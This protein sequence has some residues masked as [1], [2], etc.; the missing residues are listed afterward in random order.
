MKAILELESI[1]YTFFLDGDMIQ[2]CYTGEKLDSTQAGP[3]LDIIRVNKDRALGFLR[4]RKGAETTSGKFGWRIRWPADTYI[5]VVHGTWQ[6][7]DDGR[8]EA[9][10][11]PEQLSNALASVG[12]TLSPEQ[13]VEELGAYMVALSA[14]NDLV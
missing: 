2:Y 5:A 4:S 10:Y 9:E 1:G 11:T 14:P 12:Y 13:I 7:L 3:L 8:I 6:W